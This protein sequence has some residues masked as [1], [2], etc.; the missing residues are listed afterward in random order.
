[1]KSDMLPDMVSS[2]ESFLERYCP[3]YKDH[4]GATKD[5]P[6]ME[7]KPGQYGLLPLSEKYLNSLAY[8][9]V[10]RMQL[11]SRKEAS[12]DPQTMFRKFIEYMI[13]KADIVGAVEAEV[14]RYVFFDRN[15]VKDVKL[16][17]FC[18]DI[19]DN[20]RKGGNTVEKLLE[21]CLNSARDIMYY[22]MTANMSNKLMGGKR[23]DTWLIT[24]DK[25]LAFLS[26]S[27][28]FVPGVENTDSKYVVHERHP[29]Q[30]KSSYWNYCDAL[31]ESVVDVR[32]LLSAALGGR[33]WTAKHYDN[34]L[35]YIDD[36]EHELRT[37][38][39]T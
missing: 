27:I 30:K 32:R 39:K 15:S 18:R 12:S 1:M 23:Q 34:L 31:F 7:E 17:I 11:I 25:G 21:N 35:L 8:L 14:A 28:H 36:T 3:V 22:R 20:F 4:P 13:E 29:E 9:G 37:A 19:K 33:E 5:Y 26:D 2:F 10:L 24:G 38:Y 16:K 6:D